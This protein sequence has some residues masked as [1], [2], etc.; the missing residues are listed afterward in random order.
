MKRSAHQRLV[1]ITR[2]VSGDPLGNALMDEVLTACEEHSLGSSEALDR[3]VAAL[4]RF[5]SY[6]SEPVQPVS[7]ELFHGGP[8]EIFRWAEQQ[9]TQILS[10]RDH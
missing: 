8:E 9:T 5:N 6:L 1:D 3:L 4:N 2:S 10:S 7:A